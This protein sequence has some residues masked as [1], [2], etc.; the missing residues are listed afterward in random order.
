LF[1]SELSQIFTNFNKF[2]SLDS[3]VAE[4]HHHHHKRTD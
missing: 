4:I 2:W 3:K 1:L